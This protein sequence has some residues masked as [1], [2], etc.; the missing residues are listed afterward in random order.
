MLMLSELPPA[1]LIRALVVEQT[2]LLKGTMCTPF[3]LSR[4]FKDK[5]LEVTLITLQHVTVGIFTL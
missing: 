4:T 1:V 2:H 5:I 3:N